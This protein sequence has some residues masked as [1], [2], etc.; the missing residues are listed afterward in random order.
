MKSTKSVTSN[1]TLRICFFTHA[2]NLTGANRSLLDL[3]SGMQKQSVELRVVLRNSGPL[4]E[5][6]KSMGINYD[7]I[8][9]YNDL[10]SNNGIKTV[11]K[12]VW[13]CVALLRVCKYLKSEQFDIIH[14]NDLMSCIGMRAAKRVKIP[15]VAHMRDMIEEDHGRKFINKT[16][17]CSLL[18]GA[19]LIIYISKF[20]EKKFVAWNNNPNGIVVFDGLKIDNYSIGSRDIL[21][22]D[23]L[24]ICIVGTIKETKGQYDAL[25]GYMELIKNGYSNVSLYIIGDPRS[26]KD[27]YYTSIKKCITDN[28][29]SKVKI[30]PF[31]S[32]EDLKHIRSKCDICLVC[33]KAEA[34][35]RVT[36]ESMLAGC[37]TIGAN[38]GATSEIIKDKLNGYLYEYGDYLQLSKIIQEAIIDFEGSNIVANNGKRFAEETFD[39]FKY[40]E[41]IYHEYSKILKSGIPDREISRIL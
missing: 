7:I 39:C 6:L 20:V 11:L 27:E 10:K 29:L 17:V 30:I 18:D 26:N 14:N 2:S 25:M 32:T 33:S 23:D 34:L 1:N 31:I 3:L 8:R 40:S 5:E 15:Y 37:L 28:Q 35:G 19:S 13:N 12:R 9:Y 16:E 21:K 38:C 36:V 41:R 4:E 22:N 24:K